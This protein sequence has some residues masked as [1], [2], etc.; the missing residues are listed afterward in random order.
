MKNNLKDFIF[1]TLGTALISFGVYFFKF[2]NNF[3]TGGV[4]GISVILGAISENLS[5]GSFI[6][7]INILFLIAGFIVIGKGFGLKTAY[8]S[9]L[10][11]SIVYI[12]EI[13]MPLSSPLTSQP[14]LELIFAIALPA[15]GSALLFNI[16]ASTG[17]TDIVAMIIKKFFSINTSKALFISDFVIVM[18]T[19]FVF[20]IET[21]LYSMLGFFAKVFFVN[22]LLE[23]L[24]MS[25]YC[26]II[27]TPDFEEKIILYITENLHKSA[28]VSHSYTGAY[29]N[30]QKSV[31]L[32]AL[33][34]KQ[35]KELKNY[36]HSLDEKSFI[37]VNNT[38]EIS[39]KGFKDVL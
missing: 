38:S 19:I 18:L 14:L 31:L 21:W 34:P 3:S 32:A 20:G 25:K 35:A 29:M 8:C 1:M 30:E 26:T 2:P 28:T 23:S 16:N 17:G 36:V 7:I 39:G 22:N 37:V 33:S 13:I 9:L 4:S 6:L 11:S 15:I 12:L 24:N 10:L 5:A 27:T